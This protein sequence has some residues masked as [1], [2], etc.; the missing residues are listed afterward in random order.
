MSIYLFIYIIHKHYSSKLYLSFYPSPLVCLLF[1]PFIIKA[2]Q[3]IS[4]VYYT[5]PCLNLSHFL[6]RK[7][8]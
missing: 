7:Q 3:H 5:V 1:V 4:Q 6:A 2:C 8:F